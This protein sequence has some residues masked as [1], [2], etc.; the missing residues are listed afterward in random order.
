MDAQPDGPQVSSDASHAFPPFARGLAYLLIYR[1]ALP[2]WAYSL[3]AFILYWGVPFVVCL[4]MQIGVDP[5]AVTS[6]FARVGLPVLLPT[7]QATLQYYTSD[8]T[9]FLY[10]LIVSIG[11][12]FFVTTIRMVPVTAARLLQNGVP[13][14]P[15]EEVMELYRASVA[16]AYAW[17]KFLAAA[18]VGVAATWIL[19][20]LAASPQTV[21]W[22]GNVAHGPSGVVF[23]L[24]VG[25]MVFGLVMGIFV[26]IG[27]A[28]LLSTLAR[29]PFKLR[30]F[31][32]DGCSGMNPMGIQI[33]WLWS[34]VFFGVAAVYVALRLGYLGL[35]G[36]PLVWC[37]A[38]GGAIAGPFVAIVPVVYT[39]RAVFVAKHEELAVWERLLDRRVD[40][41]VTEMRE[42]HRS[43]ANQAVSEFNELRGVYS[44]IQEV[45]VWPFSGRA[46]VSVLAVSLLQ[47]VLVISQ[48]RSLFVG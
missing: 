42:R 17:W 14:L 24:A 27:I 1:I 29:A 25:L 34:C 48:I 19:L 28:G 16:D 15:P 20:R 22:W 26:L 23:S 33:L 21:N 6:L 43:L 30:P 4:W 44:A 46:F 9:H 31:H 32:P 18:A 7:S 41:F 10:G 35:E 38:G 3:A 12:A 5:S 45:S 47:G 39:G 8:A 40:E 11:L 13:T 37:L 2:A 36:N